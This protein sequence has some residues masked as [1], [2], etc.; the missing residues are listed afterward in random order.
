MLRKTTKQGFF[1]DAL[2]SAIILA[3]MGVCQDLRRLISVKNTSSVII[4]SSVSFE[5]S[6]MVLSLNL[7]RRI[8]YFDNHRIIQC[9]SVI[10]ASHQLVIALPH[11]V[12]QDQR[13]YT[14]YLSD[15]AKNAPITLHS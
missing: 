5:N 15:L 10:T 12:R 4:K 2:Y 13:S 6:D 1:P 7:Q 14:P 11:G 3:V 8:T 9:Q